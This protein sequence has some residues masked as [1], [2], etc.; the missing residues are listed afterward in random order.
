MRIAASRGGQVTLM[1][2]RGSP[3][4]AHL[5]RIII[6]RI[7]T[8]PYLYNRSSSSSSSLQPHRRLGL[9]E[10]RLAHYVVPGRCNVRACSMKGRE[11]IL[12]CRVSC[13]CEGMLDATIITVE[14]RNDE[15]YFVYA[16][17][18]SNLSGTTVLCWSNSL[19]SSLWFWINRI[20][21]VTR[22]FTD[23]SSELVCLTHS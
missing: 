17:E 18:I 4:C 2:R 12:I 7:Y 23:K 16:C 5:E 21:A 14:H 13:T 9:G 15:D 10:W 3:A 19:V 1:R 20:S 6:T 8:R 22:I 11:G